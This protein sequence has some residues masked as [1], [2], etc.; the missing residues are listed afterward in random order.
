MS[1]KKK[2]LRTPT[3]VL[4]VEHAIPLEFVERGPQYTRYEMLGASHVLDQGVAVPAF[5]GG[6]GV[7]HIHNRLARHE[8]SWM[9]VP[10]TKE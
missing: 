5:Y 10:F 6:K 3:G 4:D 1:A 2:P 9:L 8:V 7:L